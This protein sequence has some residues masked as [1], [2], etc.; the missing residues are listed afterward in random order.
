MSSLLRLIGIKLHNCESVTLLKKSNGYSLVARAFNCLNLHLQIGHHSIAS[1]GKV[2]FWSVL[3]QLLQRVFFLL[4][5]SF[6]IETGL[7]V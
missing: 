4:L 1:V 3:K 6:I 7:V 5:Q 2:K